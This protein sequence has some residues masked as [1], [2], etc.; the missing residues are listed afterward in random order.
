MDEDRPTPIGNRLAAGRLAK[1]LHH[2]GLVDLDLPAL[3]QEQH[4]VLR[5]DPGKFT[6]R[7]S[8]A[9]QDVAST[10]YILFLLEQDIE[11]ISRVFAIGLKATSE[12]RTRSQLYR[13]WGEMERTRGHEAAAMAAF[14]RAE[15]Q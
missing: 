5:R 1:Y 4:R 3:R 9:P 11:E 14:R 15:I 8:H 2:K 6:F 13:A 12:A 7:M 10:A